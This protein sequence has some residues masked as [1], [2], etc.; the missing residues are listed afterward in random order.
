MNDTFPESKRIQPRT[1]MQRA[2]TYAKGWAAA[3]VATVAA[4]AIARAN[5]VPLSDVGLY[6]LGVC[7]IDQPLTLWLYTLRDEAIKDQNKTI[8]AGDFEAAEKTHTGYTIVMFILL[9]FSLLVWTP[10][11]WGAVFAVAMGWL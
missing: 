3:L 2:K 7:L 10:L 5:G 9:V 1:R 8:E 4:L 11:R 6:A